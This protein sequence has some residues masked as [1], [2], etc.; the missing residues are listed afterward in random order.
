MWLFCGGDGKQRCL[1]P[2]ALFSWGSALTLVLAGAKGTLHRLRS[3]VKFDRPVVAP[4]DFF[5]GFLCVCV[6]NSSEP[7]SLPFVAL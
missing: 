1:F 5:P 4:T 3:Q 6:K 7:R 2:V